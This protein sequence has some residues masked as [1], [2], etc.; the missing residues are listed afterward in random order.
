MHGAFV[1]Y[2]FTP[3][4]DLYQT[5]SNYDLRVT[6]FQNSKQLLCSKVDAWGIFVLG[7]ETL[8]MCLKFTIVNAI[9]DL[10]NA[11]LSIMYIY[12]VTDTLL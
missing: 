9:L 4:H 8:Y 12:A 3:Y 2:L 6:A 5:L 10:G 1:T 11:S 7:G